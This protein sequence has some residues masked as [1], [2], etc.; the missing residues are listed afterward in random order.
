MIPPRKKADRFRSSWEGPMCE[1]CRR[2]FI[3]GAAALG[4]A[5]ATGISVSPLLAQARRDAAGGA[6]PPARGEFTIANAY[7]MTMDAS[8]GDI[9]GGTVHVREGAVVAGGKGIAGR[10]QHTDGHGVNV[11][12]GL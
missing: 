8:L 1:I 4:A 10:G 12:P 9:A 6:R 7:V 5:G 2:S 3:R 11:Q